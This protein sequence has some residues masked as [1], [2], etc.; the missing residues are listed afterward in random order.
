MCSPVHDNTPCRKP[1]FSE[2][3]ALTRKRYICPCTDSRQ[4]E[5]HLSKA[6]K[7][8]TLWCYT[9]DVHNVCYSVC[10][11]GLSTFATACNS[12]R[13]IIGAGRG[14]AE[15]ACRARS[16]AHH[17]KDL[18]FLPPG[19]LWTASAWQVH[20]DI[21]LVDPAK[22]AGQRRVVFQINTRRACAGGGPAE[23]GK[24][25]LRDGRR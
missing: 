23:R 14:G 17:S 11:R 10:L 5:A 1:E 2:A 15:W 4:R 8:L 20:H 9:Q 21:R 19:T 13:S 16:T 25:G 6:G 22:V 7:R 3:H 18:C 24:R 12:R